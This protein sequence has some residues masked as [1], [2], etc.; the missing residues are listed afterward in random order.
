MCDYC[1]D[2]LTTK[3]EASLI[4]TSMFRAAGP[5]SEAVF[6]GGQFNIT[7]NTEKSPGICTDGSVSAARSYKR[8]KQNLE[9][10]DD[11]DSTPLP[12][13]TLPLTGFFLFFK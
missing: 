10:L 3:A 12:L 11:D 9:P 5:F 8:I 13:K 6:H 7:R 1:D 4:K 2:N